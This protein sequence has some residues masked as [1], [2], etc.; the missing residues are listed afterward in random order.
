VALVI[1]DQAIDTSTPTGK[2]LF[3]M[4]GA[5]AEFETEIR[6]ERQV[7]GIAKAKLTED[8]ILI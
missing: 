1:L 6:S 8:Q 2:L 4:L 7:D 3:N 5:I